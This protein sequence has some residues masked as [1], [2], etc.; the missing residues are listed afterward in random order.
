MTG[1][2]Q[3]EEQT[4]ENRK[5]KYFESYADELASKLYRLKQLVKHR[6]ASGDYHEEIIRTVLRNFLTQRFSVK[7]GFIYKDE[8]HIS[9]QMDIM[10]IDEASPAAY[11]FQEGDFAVVMPE[12]VV[13]VIEVKTKL[14]GGT[15]KTAL[16]NIASA[17]ELLQYP[18]TLPGFIFGFDGSS[19][20]NPNLDRWFKSDAASRYAE[21]QVLGPD[22]V[23]FFNE[24]CLLL[25]C[26][27]EGK[28]ATAGKYYHKIFR[29]DSVKETPK[30]I[31][32]QISI[33]LATI[34]AACEAKEARVTHQFPENR[35]SR[36]VDDNGST[37]SLDRFSFGEGHT[38]LTLP[39][40]QE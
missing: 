15:F 31:G 34:V 3:N 21:Q 33:L 37:I 28:R 2:T 30:D 4:S 26:N 12:E 14:D 1:G 40:A 6:G 27:E 22:G 35:A 18:A 29:D 20:N 38:T 36:L 19:P 23:L 13:A 11:L 32:W 24:G 10:I 9:R 25:R 17:K 7:N 39:D 16:E 5:V 8:R